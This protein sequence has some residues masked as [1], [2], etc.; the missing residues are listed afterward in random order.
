MSMLSS[1]IK[2]Q[3]K[4]MG[5][6]AFMIKVLDTIVKITPSKEDDKIVAEMKK[7]LKKF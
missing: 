6:K 4:K 7:V 5:V 1:Y 2:R 3:I